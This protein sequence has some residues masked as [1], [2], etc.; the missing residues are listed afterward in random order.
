M[1]NN[2]N[3]KKY[4]LIALGLSLLGFAFLVYYIFRASLDVVASD[5]IRIINYYLEDVTDLKYLLSWEGISRIPFTFLARYINVT[6]FKY[7]V[8]FDRILGILLQ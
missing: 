5:Y 7:S 1:V 8:H 3:N 2:E 4:N 6:Y